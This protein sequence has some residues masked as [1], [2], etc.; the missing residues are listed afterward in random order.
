M[1][2]TVSRKTIE[3]IANTATALRSIKKLE[4]ANRRLVTAFGKDAP[5]AVKVLGTSL[6]DIKSKKIIDE[7]G[8]QRTIPVFQKL[9]TTIQTADGKVQTFTE[10]QKFLKNGT[11]KVT[12]SLQNMD[13]NTVSLGQNIARLAKRA[14]LTIPLWLA[15]RSAMTSVT[16]TI[17]DGL[18][19]IA[20]QDRALQKARR[21]LQGTTQQIN[22]NYKTL[23]DSARKL[24]IETGQSVEDIVNAFQKFATVGFDFETSLEGANNAT[25]LSILLFGDAE[26]TANA[27]ARTM[28]VLVDESDKARDAGQQIAEAMAQTSKLWETNAFELNEF[29]ESLTKFAPTAKTMNLSAQQ[30]IALLSALSTAGLR[31]GRA[32]RLL[33][34]AFT[35]LITQTDKLAKSLGVKVNPEVDKTFD[36][37]LRTLNAMEKT[38]DEAGRVSPEF[39]KVVKSIVGLRS[40]DAIKGLIAL[41]KELNK[42]LAVTGD[43]DEFNKS[44]ED[45]NSQ[46]FK[47]IEQFHNLN[48]EIGK[49]FVTGLVGGE[50]FKNSL[51]EITEALKVLQKRA[52]TTGLFFRSF[53]SPKAFFGLGGVRGFISE[54]ISKQIDEGT[55]KAKK[56]ADSFVKTVNKALSEELDKNA[57]SE[58]LTDFRAKIKENNLIIPDSTIAKLEGTLRKQLNESFK[59]DPI[60][61]GDTAQGFKKQQ[62]ISKLLID[63]IKQEAEVR[64]ALESEALRLVDT[65]NK[66]FGI[67]EDSLDVLER[68]LDIE[69]TIAEEKRLQ[70]RLGSESIKLFRIA[71]EEGSNVAKKIGEILAGETD[72]NL[73]VKKGGKALE[74]FK[75][76]FSGIFEAK[77]AE[78]FFKGLTVPGEKDLRGG[79]LIPIE[80][81][82]RQTNNE[83]VRNAKTRLSLA[84]RR[85]EIEKEIAQIEGRQKQRRRETAGKTFVP[86][87]QRKISSPSERFITSKEIPR[88]PS[89]NFTSGGINISINAKNA[90]DLENQLKSKFREIEQKTL[91]DVKNKLVGKQSPSL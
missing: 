28:R 37:F 9:G 1:A 23:Q 90:E 15:L 87:E 79:A 2:D 68:K 80:E 41:R 39:E 82:I 56:S 85:L 42:N 27:F 46:I 7:K 11:A 67:E 29:T 55:E 6:S 49:G 50:D 22:D 60:D 57:L 26:E 18:K 10:N 44:F 4:Q 5:K 76:E 63:Q 91:K 77:Q 66:Q 75:K 16:K 3:Y 84:K 88:T 25:K 62:D 19:T 40:S 12:G 47:L 30:T 78:R 43:V 54:S 31:G 13:K 53:L 48:R 70:S 71:K 73:F 21:N 8:I 33:R 65:L 32:G 14:A 36:V 17:S 51:E 83:I 45:V 34:T 20:E 69:R 35:K 81:N 89:F 24:S 38:R 72:F 74:V 64:G 61:L 58:L 52:E 86:I 59:K